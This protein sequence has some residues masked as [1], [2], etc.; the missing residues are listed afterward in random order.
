MN[1]EDV[2]KLLKNSWNR[3][4]FGASSIFNAINSFDQHS[5]PWI[6]ALCAVV[7][8]FCLYFWLINKEAIEAELD[9]AGSE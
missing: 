7:A 3:G 8:A 6:R 5:A 2:K 1:N 4:W 9:K